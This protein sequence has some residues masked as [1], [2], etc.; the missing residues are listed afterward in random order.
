MSGFDPNSISSTS[1]MQDTSAI[2]NLTN[3]QNPFSAP[4]YDFS[5]TVTQSPGGNYF[6]SNTPQG[7][8]GAMDQQVKI[9]GAEAM[10]QQAPTNNLGALMLGRQMLMQSQPQAPQKQESI[11]Q[12]RKG[13]QVNMSDPIGALLAPKL[14]KKQPISLL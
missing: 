4:V 10:K 6:P 1:T 13:Q 14:K 12:V 3:S 9:A 7:N 11:A 2:A 8:I 5:T